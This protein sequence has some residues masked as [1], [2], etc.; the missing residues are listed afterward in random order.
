MPAIRD[1]QPR[2]IADFV[3]AKDLCDELERLRKQGVTQYFVESTHH[4]QWRLIYVDPSD[5]QQ[6]V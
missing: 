5:D 2:K 3:C 4:N 6:R 1:N